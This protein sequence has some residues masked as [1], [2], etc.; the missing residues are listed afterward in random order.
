MYRARTRMILGLMAAL[1]MAAALSAAEDPAF[2][3]KE[4]VIYGR[5]HG[6]ALTMDIFTPKK[7]A[8]EI[9][10]VLVISGGFVSSHEAIRPAL[11]QPLTDRGYTVFAVVHGSQPKFTVPE[12][13]EDMHRAVRFI[14]Y[15]AREYKVDPERLGVT[16][17]SAGGHLSLLLG[18]SGRPGDPK[19]SDPVERCKNG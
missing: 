19:A 5:K 12:I 9:G 14:R 7:D 1:S 10:V 13:V 3:R 8:K 6:T 15:H 4:D 2:D 17:A 16:G 18:T 11:V